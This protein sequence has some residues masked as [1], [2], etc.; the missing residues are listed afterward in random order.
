VL[1]AGLILLLLLAAAP[2]ASAASPD[3]DLPD[4]VSELPDK[5][6]V[7]HVVPIFVDTF[8]RPGA[9]LYRFDS[10]IGNQG[11][12]VDLWKDPANGHVMQAV[13]P[14]GTPSPDPDPNTVPSGAGVQIH[15]L[16]A[17]GTHIDF[18][19]DDNH[20]HFHFFTAAS[21]QLETPAGLR[22]SPKVGF[23]L[24]DTFSRAERHL[25]EDGYRGSGPATW[26]DPEQVGN[27]LVRMGLSPRGGGDLYEAATGLNWVDVTGLVPGTYTLRVTANPSGQILES[28]RTN[29]VLRVKRVIPGV[30]A[31]GIVARSPSGL[32][33]SLPL[34]AEVLAPAVPGRSSADCQPPLTGDRCY[35]RT[36]A[37]G[38]LRFE[39][40]RPPAHGTA[41]L[42]TTSGADARVAYQP[43]DGFS[44]TD[45]FTYAA[46]DARGLRSAVETVV[47]LVGE[48]GAV[49][50]AFLRRAGSRLRA[51]LDLVTRGRVTGTVAVGGRSRKIKAVTLKPG[52]RRVDL[53]AWRAGR[54]TVRLK[55]IGGRA[56]S[57][58]TLKAT[59]R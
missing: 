58:T 38:P 32:T 8:E 36:S 43:A 4:L 42:L 55:V 26:C 46:T 47:V 30:V 45:S 5:P 51:E 17:T 18:V 9:I 22:T 19:T 28:D 49:A 48:P 6:H 37:R 56:T 40:V 20:D 59:F 34:A 3:A 29:N 16:S 1:R 39:V 33:T 50:S 12:A 54:V 52:H 23:C 53:G 35:V 31:S 57:R 10:V 7:D 14:G 13:W 41:V 11:G 21:Y 27:G 2:A 44:G 24:H 25:Y 15:D